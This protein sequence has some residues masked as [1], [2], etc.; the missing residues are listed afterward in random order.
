MVRRLV[1]DISQVEDISLVGGRHFTDC[2]VR[3]LVC[4]EDEDED[5]PLHSNQMFVFRRSKGINRI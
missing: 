3:V 1:E 4:E 2:F 5:G